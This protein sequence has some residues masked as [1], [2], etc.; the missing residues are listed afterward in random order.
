MEK[1]AIIIPA[2]NEEKRIETTLKNYLSYFRNLK[3]DKIVDFEIIIVLN[4]CTDNTLEVVNKFK[5]K[6][7]KIL[8]FKQGGKGFAILEGFK[9][10][11][12]SRRNLVGFVDA[13][14]S[15]P[16][17]AF[18]D[19]IKNIGNFD[20]IIADRWNKKSTITPKQNIFRRLISRGYNFIVR[21]MFV[22]PYRD[23]QC[24]AKLF[25][26]NILKK[27][28]NKLISSNWNFDVALLFCLRKESN[29]KIRSIPTEWHDQIGSKVNLR[30]TPL[31][32]F[33]AALRLRLIHSPFRGLV[34]IY[35]KLPE[36]LKLHN[37]L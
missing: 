21:S 32:M 17:R 6:D 30:R 19:L 35:R 28:V 2:Y 5:G 11:L 29:A 4:G 31:K 23:T 37:K 10:S 25:T 27:N 18:F 34:I 13:D 9:A 26:R 14:G 33:L 12:K 7:V 15:T 3:K 36:K 24:G 20:G 22:F 8:N 16:A 1:V